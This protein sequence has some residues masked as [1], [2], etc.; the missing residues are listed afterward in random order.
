MHPF[1]VNTL[2][3]AVSSSIGLGLIKGL[4]TSCP[5]SVE[6]NVHCAQLIP[7]L[8]RTQIF[9]PPDVHSCLLRDEIRRPSY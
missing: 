4:L 3:Q 6:V 1:D 8:T 2:R 7:V 5:D 9:A